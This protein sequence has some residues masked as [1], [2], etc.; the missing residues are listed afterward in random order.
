[1]ER[2][3]KLPLQVLNEVLTYLGDRPYKEVAPLVSGIQ[4]NF[5]VIVEDTPKLDKKKEVKK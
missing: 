5:K 1:M 3:V 2:F 4:N